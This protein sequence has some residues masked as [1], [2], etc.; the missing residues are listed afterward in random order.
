MTNSFTVKEMIIRAVVVES[1]I[2]YVQLEANVWVINPIEE[3]E[4]ER[5]NM[6]LAPN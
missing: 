1:H 6:G 4:R 3:R 5:E 2:I